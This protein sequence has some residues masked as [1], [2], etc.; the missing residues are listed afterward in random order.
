MNETTIESIDSGQARAFRR[1]VLRGLKRVGAV[2]LISGILAGCCVMVDE[3]EFVIIERLGEIRA[4]F[5]RPT[6]RGLHFRFPWPIENVRRF[7]RRLQLFDPPGREVFTRDRKN[8]T[9]D[10]FVCWKIA[11]P[12]G[13]SAD[14]RTRPV[15]RFFR[16][17]GSIDVAEARLDNR[18]RSVL[19]THVGQVEFMNLFNVQDSERGPTDD[20]TGLI[21]RISR[22]VLEQVRRRP[23][24]DVSI[25]EQ[26]GIDVVDVRIKRINF[27]AGNQ[28][29][30]FDRMKSERRR[31]AE[32]YRS[33][34]MAENLAI[35]SRADRRY[36]AVLARAKGDAE[37]IRG[38]G[39]AQAI[40]I[41]NQAHAQDPEFHQIMRTLDTYRSIVNDRTTLVLSA[42]SN[43]FKL[44][45]QGIPDTP[46]AE[47]VVPEPTD[48]PTRRHSRTSRL[49]D[50]HH[51][52]SAS[53]PDAQ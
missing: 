6:D 34:G 43:L 23:G 44:L 15:V 11:E 37:R 41:L 13:A 42:S 29:A 48:T 38:E 4:V 3:T 19:N 7:D 28:Q 40:A 30:V 46:S 14:A 8:I 51:G 1:R 25:D 39:E 20:E 50:A 47:R 22:E 33:S 52:H 24:D 26:L 10:A 12:D 45:T 27:P 21:E 36:N 18:V 17:L 2:I 32:G 31:I 35:R 49:G 5:D 16:G 9:V 53:E